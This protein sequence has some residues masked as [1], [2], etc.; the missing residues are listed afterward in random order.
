MAG[1]NFHAAMRSFPFMGSPLLCTPLG[2][3]MLASRYEE[4]EMKDAEPPLGLAALHTRRKIHLQQIYQANNANRLT[5][6]HMSHYVFA[7]QCPCFNSLVAKG[8]IVAR[9]PHYGTN[10]CKHDDGPEDRP[11]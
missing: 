11:Y 4:I 8:S 10:D 3:Y 7:L 6:S 5:P 9:L 2:R 1:G